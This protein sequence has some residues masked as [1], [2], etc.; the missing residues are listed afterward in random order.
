MVKV[1]TIIE[2]FLG[3]IFIVFRKQ[4]V[5]I[6]DKYARI[7]MGRRKK[8]I[9]DEIEK[10][11]EHRYFYIVQEIGYIIIGVILITL[12]LLEL[13]APA[14]KEYGNSVLGFLILFIISAA[15]AGFCIFRIVSPILNRRLDKYMN[16]KYATIWLQ[17]RNSSLAEKCEAKR[18]V[19]Q[20]ND[21]IYKKLN[22]RVKIYSIVWFIIL[23]I[24]FIF[25]FYAS[26]R[27]ASK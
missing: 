18:S 10:L 11:D 22:Q 21:P 19:E 23:M 9:R 12:G 13:I 5:R 8:Q 14:A 26:M 4:I 16:D 24:A 17:S 6:N 3:V 15:I 27:L 1:G 2:L 7:W 25:T 20:L